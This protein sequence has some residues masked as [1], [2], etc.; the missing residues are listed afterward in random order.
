[1]GSKNISM[2]TVYNIKNI[3][4]KKLLHLLLPITK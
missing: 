3:Q 2:C 4:D 1:M